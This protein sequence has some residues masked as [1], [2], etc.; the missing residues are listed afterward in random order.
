[1]VF[2]DEKAWIDTN[3]EQSSKWLQDGEEGLC[4]PN[5]KTQPPP[6]TPPCGFE[7]EL[8]LSDRQY[9]LASEE[10]GMAVAGGLVILL[11]AV[12]VVGYRTYKYEQV[13]QSSLS[14]TIVVCHKPVKRCARDTFSFQQ[15]IVDQTVK[16]ID[17]K[18]FIFLCI[19]LN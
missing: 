6:S 10:V 8:C 1:M 7:D 16:D 13:S 2:K 19:S 9:H 4:W 14:L 5:G 12:I 11:I 15:I 17:P 3:N 18:H